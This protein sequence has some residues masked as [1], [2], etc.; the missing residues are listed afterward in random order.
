[1][2]VD[3]LDFLE[4][5]T[6]IFLLIIPRQALRPLAISWP[7]VFWSSSPGQYPSMAFERTKRSL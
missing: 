3:S 1:M 4:A 2:G 5:R 6:K 7:V